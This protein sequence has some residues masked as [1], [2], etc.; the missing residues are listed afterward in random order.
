MLIA[1]TEANAQG[2]LHEQLLM[3][4]RLKEEYY[5]FADQV[6]RFDD[7]EWICDL[8]KGGF[9]TVMMMRD[10]R[11]NVPVALKVLRRRRMTTRAARMNAMAEKEVTSKL[12]TTYY[13]LLLTTYYSLLTR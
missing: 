7:L 11:R 8:G 13:L 3:H 10:V 5:A 9:G 1:A 2:E 6:M 4:L 12:L